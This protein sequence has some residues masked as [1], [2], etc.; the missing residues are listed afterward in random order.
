MSL[1]ERDANPETNFT[2]TDEAWLSA[3]LAIIKKGA[4]LLEEVTAYV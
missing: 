3:G 1:S 4:W 2:Q